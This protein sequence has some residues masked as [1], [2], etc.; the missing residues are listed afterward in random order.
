MYVHVH[1][2]AGHDRFFGLY[3]FFFYVCNFITL[4]DWRLG[5]N[6]IAWNHRTYSIIFVNI[7]IYLFI[8]SFFPFFFLSQ[9]ISCKINT[10]KTS[11]RIM[12]FICCHL[13]FVLIR[14]IF[15]F[16]L[17]FLPVWVNNQQIE[18]FESDMKKESRNI[19]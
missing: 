18:K 5:I 1:V 2:C 12:I 3:S 9:S 8:F 19:F 14:F 16:F 11:N 13:N 7:S 15:S 10:S 6:T 17:L 4:K